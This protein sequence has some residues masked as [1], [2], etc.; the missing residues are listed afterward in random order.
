MRGKIENN[1]LGDFLDNL[2]TSQERTI[3]LINH[4]QKKEKN[5]V[6]LHAIGRG[7]FIWES[8]LQCKSKFR[9][10]GAKTP[11]LLLTLNNVDLV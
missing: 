10:F 9:E 4:S 1:V 5:S 7:L 8:S 11:K 2:P 3:L 6:N